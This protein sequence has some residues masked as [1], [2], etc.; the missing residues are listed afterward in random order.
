M[1][2]VGMKAEEDASTLDVASD[3]E[4]GMKDEKQDRRSSHCMDCGAIPLRLGMME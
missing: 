1:G 2:S 3:G 4:T